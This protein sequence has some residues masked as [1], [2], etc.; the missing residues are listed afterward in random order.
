MVPCTKQ[1]TRKHTYSNIEKHAIYSVFTIHTLHT[2]QTIMHFQR[3]K[4]SAIFLSWTKILPKL[5]SLIIFLN[6]EPIGMMQ[7]RKNKLFNN[8]IKL[9]N[10]Q[11]LSKEH[12]ISTAGAKK[13]CCHFD[14]LVLLLLSKL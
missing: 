10:V 11:V 6:V 2:I 1:A 5:K 12:C 13:I 14:V 8:T 3:I 7:Y 9:R 4:V